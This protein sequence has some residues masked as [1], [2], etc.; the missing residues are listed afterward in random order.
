MRIYFTLALAA[1]AFLILPGNLFASS[2]KHVKIAKEHCNAM[3]ASGEDSLAHGEKGHAGKAIKHLK[4][5]IHEAEECINHGQGGIKASD[6]SKATRTH[7]PE[8]MENVAEA[9]AHARSALKHG[10]KDHLDL[11]I[12]HTKDALAYAYEGNNHASEMN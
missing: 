6:A 1:V 10:M 2:A 12:D 9:I 7:G 11:M 5:M 3:V 8:A 4:K